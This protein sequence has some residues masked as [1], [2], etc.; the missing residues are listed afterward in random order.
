[1]F[2]ITIKDIKEILIVL[3]IIIIIYHFYLTY[4]VCSGSDS[5]DIFTFKSEDYKDGDKII[6]I[7]GGTHGNEPAGYY[8]IKSLMNDLTENKIKLKSCKLILIPQVNYCGLK[9]G[10]RFIPEIGDLNRKYPITPD[11]KSS[12]SIIKKIMEQ[13]K[14]SDFVLDFHEGWGFNRLNGDSMGST[15]TPTN[16]ELSFNISRD[17]FSNINKNLKDH[18]RFRILTTN[19]ALVKSDPDLFAVETDIPG[20]LRFYCNIINKDY[21]LIETT[22]Q[23]NIQELSVRINQNLFIINHILKYNL[24]RV[25]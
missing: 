23:N 13:V 15:I 20:S 6:L 7:I 10:L 11:G 5:I 21:I 19:L 2:N 14:I 25:N 24:R 9:L 18:K 4:N 1:M 3:A 8:A 12:N 16:T 22:G 17:L